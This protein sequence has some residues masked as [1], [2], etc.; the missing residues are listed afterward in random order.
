MIGRAIPTPLAPPVQLAGLEEEV[1]APS[2]L[3]RLGGVLPGPLRVLVV[4]V[5]V[6]VVGCCCHSWLPILVATASTSS[7]SMSSAIVILG[8]LGGFREFGM[9]W[10]SGVRM[11][12]VSSRALLPNLLSICILEHGIIAL[13]CPTRWG[14][15][16]QALH[17]RV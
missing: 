11:C 5:L 6:V 16:T 4:L 10:R 17:S 3:T 14:H 1:L 7:T 2:G 9:V 8:H 13:P 15:S 12:Q